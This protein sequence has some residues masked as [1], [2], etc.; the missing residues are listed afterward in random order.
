M[1]Q[2]EIE[3]REVKSVSEFVNLV[4]QECLDDPTPFRDSSFIPLAEPEP[5]RRLPSAFPPLSLIP[6]RFRSAFLIPDSATCIPP[7]H[8]HPLRFLAPRARPLSIFLCCHRAL[9]LVH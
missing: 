9:L 2:E 5:G 7:P 4:E 8:A 3:G 1:A 6:H